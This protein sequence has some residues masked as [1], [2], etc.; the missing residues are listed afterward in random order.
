MN[1]SAFYYEVKEDDP[2]IENIRKDEEFYEYKKTSPRIYSKKFLNLREEI[3]DSPDIIDNFEYSEEGFE[4]R[5]P[6]NKQSIWKDLGIELQKI[7]ILKPSYKISPTTKELD[8]EFLKNLF[9]GLPT[10]IHVTYVDKYI[11][12]NSS[13]L[14]ITFPKGKSVISTDILLP[15]FNKYINTSIYAH[16]LTHAEMNF[17]GSGVDYYINKETIPIFIESLFADK[18]DESG[19]TL[20]LSLNNRLAYLSAI[21]DALV[22][23]K[24]ASFERRMHLEKYFVSILQGITLYNRYNEGSDKVKNEMINHINNIFKGEELAEEMLVRFESKYNDV[25][26]KVKSLKKINRK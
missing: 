26:P 14:Q 15:K 21:I 17:V 12:T 9:I 5:F 4:K 10:R 3:L 20:E 22:N 2:S 11:E 23:E 13:G 6:R 18:V 19:N 7:Q 24:N 25:E 8:Q 16:E 1:K